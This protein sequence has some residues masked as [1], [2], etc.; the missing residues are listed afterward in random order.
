MPRPL[1]NA[2]PRKESSSLPTGLPTLEQFTAYQALAEYFNQQLFGGSLPPVFLNFSRKGRRTRGFFAPHRWEKAE[3]V[4]HEISL[5]PQFLAAGLSIETAATLAHEM[6]HLWQ[7]VYGTPSRTRYHNRE[8]ADKMEAVGLMPSDTGQPGGKR[9]GQQ[10][11]HY[12]LP[13]GS[14]AQ[15]FAALP[16]GCSLPWT[17]NEPGRQNGPLD[18][19]PPSKVK[20]TCPGCG[21]NAWGKPA[22]RLVCGTCNQPLGAMAITG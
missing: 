4:T 5:N 17:C 6:V 20:Y 16:P 14:F 9:T 11:S 3:T 2:P 18:R 8:W 22:L 10:M 1:T 21:A 7:Q 12:V 13:N 15:V 19:R